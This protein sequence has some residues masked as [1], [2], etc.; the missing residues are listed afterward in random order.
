MRILPRILP[1]KIIAVILFIASFGCAIAFGAGFAY[2]VAG[3]YFEYPQAAD[4]LHSE[5]LKNEAADALTTAALSESDRDA[6]MKATRDTNFVF[7]LK[8]GDETLFTSSDALTYPETHTEISLPDGNVLSAELMQNPTVRNNVYYDYYIYDFVYSA[9][10]SF[11]IVTVS[12]LA[13]ALF[14]GYFIMCGAGRRR[15]SEEIHLN[16]ADRLPLDLYVLLLFAGMFASGWLAMRLLKEMAL[17]TLFLII[18][19]LLLISSFTAALLDTVAKRVKSGTWWNEMLTKKLVVFTW[20]L[21]CHAAGDIEKVFMSLTLIWKALIMSSLYLC[22]TLL[23]LNSKSGVLTVLWLIVSVVAIIAICLAVISAEKIRQGAEKLAQGD[24]SYRID[25][26]DMLPV[27]RQHANN[28]NSI[29]DVLARAVE[30]RTRSEK[31]KA[32]LITNVSHDIKTPITSIINYVDLLGRENLTDEQRAQYLDVLKR[33][34]ARLKKLTVDLVEASKA[35]TGNISVQTEPLD[36]CEI[37]KQSTGEFS[38][39]I[40]DSSLTLELQLTDGPL[41]IMADGRLLW[42]VFENLLSNICKYSQPG[43]R[44][45]V[46]TRVENGCVVTDFKNISRERLSIPGK[47]LTERFVRG[48]S[49]RSTEGS[50]LGLSIAKSFTELQGGSFDIITDGDLFKAEIRFPIVCGTAAGEIAKQ[51]K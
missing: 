47:D 21:I 43:T 50:G 3:G 36:V 4:Y 26:E 22:I 30:E 8:S 2:A 25:T 31:F 41:M 33:Q 46:T 6:F 13:A 14:F 19:C 44:V 20:G 37:L 45:Y 27:F 23:T 29:N 38:E 11:C 18:P 24:L 40:A 28:L 35:S 39:R 15:K 32:E 1:L 9:R 17:W 16:M 34:S 5:Q 48:D 42:R 51:G 12:C 7:T 49:S 10:Y